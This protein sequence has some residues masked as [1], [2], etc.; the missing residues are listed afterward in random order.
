[1]GLID[2]ILGSILGGGAATSS[3]GSMAGPSGGILKS[4]LSMLPLGGGLASLMQL[5]QQKGMSDVFSSWVST[6]QNKPVTGQQLTEVFGEE[7]IASMAQEMGVSPEECSTQL[8]EHLPELVDKMTPTGNL[9][10][11]DDWSQL[12]ERLK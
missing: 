9:P 6:G 7:K 1:M 11:D 4:V 8:S 3:K 2:S 12:M 5:F 10:S